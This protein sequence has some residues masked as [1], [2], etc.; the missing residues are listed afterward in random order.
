MTKY[1]DCLALIENEHNYVETEKK[2]FKDKAKEW[3]PRLRDALK[4]E[5]MSNDDIKDR[6]LKDCLQHWTRETIMNNLG[7]EFKDEKFI[8][9][10]KKGVKKKE[11]IAL[12]QQTD[13]T[14]SAENDGN[15]ARIDQEIRAKILNTSDEPVGETTE[16]DGENSITT[17]VYEVH[18]NAELLII[19]DREIEMLKD[20]VKTLNEKLVESEDIRQKIA[21]ESI[22][23]KGPLQEGGPHRKD[24]DFEKVKIHYTEIEVKE[25]LIPIKIRYKGDFVPEI[26][27]DHI[28]AKRIYRQ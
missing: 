7:E 2:K 5:K 10:G 15:R 26:E 23:K 14:S 21:I 28:K 4:E 12:T 6:I 19:K 18:N 9:A 20:R 8:E 3:V 1:D 17:N 13:G 27:I 22:G 16:Q 24:Q 25:H 11:E